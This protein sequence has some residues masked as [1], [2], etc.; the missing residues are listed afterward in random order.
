MAEI[1]LTDSL[2]ETSEQRAARSIQEIHK[3][4]HEQM[5]RKISDGKREEGQSDTGRDQNSQSA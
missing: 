5:M 1:D 4:I 2:A 3:R